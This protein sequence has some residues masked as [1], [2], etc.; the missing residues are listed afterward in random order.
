MTEKSGKDLIIEDA[1]TES[2][3]KADQEFDSTYGNSGS[4]EVYVR[5]YLLPT[6]EKS[7]LKVIQEDNSVGNNGQICS[8]CFN[9]AKICE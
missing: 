1:L 3:R 4:T 5:D 9:A 2:V 6:L 7:G 8:N